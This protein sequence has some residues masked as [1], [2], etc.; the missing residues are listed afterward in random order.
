MKKLIALLLALS[1]LLGLCACARP[2]GGDEATQPDAGTEDNG[3]STSTGITVVVPEYKDYG[4]DTVDFDK[5]VYSRPN[6]QSVIDGFAA[7]TAAVEANATDVADQIETIR[8]LEAPLSGVRS[9]YA[10][11]Q[12]Y[13]NTD[14]SVE[15]WQ[16]E[17]SYISTNYPRLTRS[18]EDLLV[19][20]ARSEHRETFEKDY[21]GYSLEE[22]VDG[23]IYSDEVVALME[24]EAA[25][26]SE[27]TSI[28]TANVKITYNSSASSDIRW[29]GTVDEVIA[30]AKDY[31]KYDTDS[32]ERCL[33]AIDVL[34][35]KARL[36]IEKPLFIELLRIR[37]HI[38]DELDYDSY[39]ELA[40]ESMG[41][42]YSPAEM[43][44]LLTDIG[45]YAA[46]VASDLEHTVFQSYFISNVQ[47]KVSRTAV[48][49]TLYEVYSKLGGDYKDAY[50]Y[51]LQH[52]LYDVAPSGSNRYDGAFTAYIDD[53]ASPYLFMTSTGFIRDYTTLSHEFGHFLD[54][55]VNYG[56]DASLSVSEISSQALELLTLT[57]LKNNIHAR[58]Y[59]YLEYY[60][61]FTYLNSVLL[62]QSFYSAFEHMAYELS[63][64]DITEERLEKTVEDAFTL[65]FGNEMYIDGDLSYV[66]IAHTFLY[67]FYVESY[68][69]A[70]LV[71]LDIFFMESSMTGTAGNGFA[72]YDALIDRGDDELSFIEL[73]DKVGLDSPF[74]SG[75]VKEIADNIYFQIVGKR[76]YKTGDNG[77]GAA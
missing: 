16:N 5:L 67:P 56:N 49:N 75:K 9:M 23:G 54:G 60:T 57:K 36:E 70:G 25:L 65:V 14:S 42:D 40:Y 77:I 34:Y 62:T 35:E 63:Y 11:A 45:R 17:Y 53:N 15:Y 47:P 18:V 61:M 8:A 26:E 55:Y 27:Y 7:A 76:Y 74:S 37:R 21:F 13:N 71:S 10:L 28:S 48:I 68:V 44:T 22:Y 66:T 24:Q 52:G 3:G 38:A 73:L 41:Y 43:L 29:S 51:M 46:P 12:I 20:C 50:S 64:D 59:L 31:Y 19:A 32:Y 6:M 4:R 69:S 2:D 33:L 72:V 39:S 30:M 1:M 58:Y